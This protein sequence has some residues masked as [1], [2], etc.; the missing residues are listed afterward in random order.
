MQFLKW[1]LAPIQYQMIQL[2]VCLTIL[3]LPHWVFQGHWGHHLP[4]WT[5]ILNPS[6]RYSSALLLCTHC[7]WPVPSEVTPAVSLANNWL[8]TSGMHRDTSLCPAYHSALVLRPFREIS[9]QDELVH[10]LFMWNNKIVLPLVLKLCVCVC[11]CVC[12]LA[13]WS[14]PIHWCGGIR[15]LCVQS[16]WK[17]LWTLVST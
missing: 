12:A 1:H 10:W 9:L 16:L 17:T 5:S 7:Q 8:D 4:P 2:S 15:A 11:V 14:L 13:P 6:L 3:T